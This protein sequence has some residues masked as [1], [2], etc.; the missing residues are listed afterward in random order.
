MLMTVEN[1]MRKHRALGNFAPMNAQESALN[2]YVYPEPTEEWKALMGKG[3]TAIYTAD[4]IEGENLAGMIQRMKREQSTVPQELSLDKILF[5]NADKF[6]CR[7]YSDFD[8]SGVTASIHCLN[9]IA[10][11][12][13]ESID[14]FYKRMVHT[15]VL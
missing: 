6:K 15:M 3:P 7:Y 13:A 10:P 2:P 12:V 1:A 8:M 4:D 14:F 9:K 11:A 5:F